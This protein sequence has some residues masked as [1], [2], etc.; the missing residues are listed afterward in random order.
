MNVFAFRFIFLFLWVSFALMALVPNKTITQY[1]MHIWNMES[2]LPGNSV[3]AIQ[4]TQ[5]GYLWIG[6]Q[7]GLVRFDGLN[8]ELY[9]KKKNPQLKSNVIRALYEDR[10]GTL[11]IGTTSGGLTY[12]KEGEFFTYPIKDHKTLYRISAINEDQWGT[13]WIGSFSEGLTCLRDGKFTTYTTKQGLPHNQV[14]FI[15]KDGNKNI[16]VTTTAGIVKLLEPGRFQVYASQDLLPYFKTVSLYDVDTKNLWIGTRENGLFRLKNGMLKSYGVE[17]G[18]PLLTINYLYKDRMAN[19]W[20]GTDGGGLTRMR[21]DVLNTLPADDLLTCGFVYSIYEDREGN[22]WVGTL[23]GGLHQFRD[24][25]FS[26]YTTREGMLHDYIGCISEGRANGLWIGTEGGLNALRLKDGKL[27]T[28]LTT[29]KGRLNDSVFCLF[30]DREGYLWIG[31]WGSGVYRFKEGELT[32]FLT[33]KEGLSD[34]RISY[35][36]KDSQGNTWIGTSSGLDRLND[37]TGKITLFNREKGFSG[38]FITF[39]FEDS[40]G[41]LWIGTDTGLNFLR[42]GVINACNLASELE[43]NFFRCAYEGKKGVLWFG[44][45]GGLIR[46]KGNETILYTTQCGLVEN[47]VYSILEDEKGYLWLGGRNGISR[48]RK[49]ELEDFSRGLINKVKPGSYNEKDG[50]KSRWCTSDGCKTRDGRFWFPTSVGVTMIDPNHIKTNRVPPPLII[51]KIV[52]DDKP[53]KINHFAGGQEPHGAIL[54]LGPGKKRLEFYYTGVSFINPQEIRFKIKLKGYDSDWINMGNLRS[55]TYTGLSPGHYTFKVIASNPD[56]VRNEKGASLAFYLKPYFYQTTW[57]YLLVGLLILM[58]A[59]SLYRFRIR[60]LRTREKELGALVE[61]RTRDLKER[62]IELEKA[63]RK[64][65]QSKKIIEEKNRNIMDSIR[66]ARKIQQ[67]MLPIKEKMEK[68]LKDYFVIYEPKDIVSGDFYWFDMVEGQYFLAV[69]DCTG[70][71]VPGALLSMIGCMKLNEVVNDM[72]IFNPSLVLSHLHQG[73]RSV[74]KQEIEETDTHDGMDVGVC[75]IDL[76]TGKITF[77]GAGRPL[78]YVKGSKLV[79]VKGDRKSIGG[80]QKEEKRSFTNHEIDILGK[81]L[82]KI[83]LYLTTDGFADQHNPQNQ[84]YGS[85]RLKKFLKDHAHLNTVQQKAALVEELKK[86][87]ANEEQRDD[88]TIIGIHI[89]MPFSHF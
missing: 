24:S 15:H 77:A 27:T 61:L 21:D 28:V 86:H 50:M 47:Y 39:V 72:H 57:F 64:L 3:F 58:T 26:T 79:E 83:M 33:T 31:T 36:M 66:Y 70:H 73:F 35:I 44:T 20:I 4:Q 78:F 1:S 74:L 38:N 12:L 11:W 37:D 7:D 87:R 84:K 55:A 13:L 45:D 68:E 19:L 51:E 30:E 65:R 62:T 41:R 5:D 60:Q 16:W 22:L 29:G 75:R 53:I 69:A 82:E 40:K 49:K 42:E 80:R 88:I 89:P 14:R 8:F 25:K 43:N 56:G 10:R 52:V 81:K 9:N 46:L 6:T 17:E 67:S 34:N 23:D 48:V 2:G 85:R 32:P 76:K 59:F 63:Q 18:I 71:G 54:E